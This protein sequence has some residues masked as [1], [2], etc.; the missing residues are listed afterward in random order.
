MENSCNDFLNLKDDNNKLNIVSKNNVTNVTA[1]WVRS[2]EFGEKIIS[3][4][5]AEAESRTG[6][7]VQRNFWCIRQG[8]RWIRSGQ[9]R[10]WG[11]ENPRSGHHRAIRY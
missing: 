4:S 2:S 6:K 7:E 9:R 11:Y 3:W 5:E 10:S 1:D 8:A